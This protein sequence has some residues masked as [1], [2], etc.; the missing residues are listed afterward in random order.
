MSTIL[1]TPCI[2]DSE[3]RIQRN[4]KWLEYYIPLQDKLGYDDIVMVDN[5]SPNENLN[6]LSS[7]FPQVKFIKKTDRIER[8]GHLGYEYWYRAFRE[9]IRYARNHAYNKIIHIDSDG[10]LLS[11]RICEDVKN[12]NS[13]WNCYWCEAHK[14]PDTIFQIIGSDQI[15]NAYNFMSTGYLPH[16]G[17]RQAE[18]IVPFTNVNKSFIG[19]R[20]PD[21]GIIIQ[22]PNWD[23]CAQVPLSMN[24]KFNV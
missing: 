8:V 5:A 4:I 10:F 9:A 16:Y 11:N 12:L 17:K 1:F 3:E 14:F 7:A 2:L 13:G 20:Y 24:I 22:D 15:D 21:K 23:Y 18:D 6:A 19:D